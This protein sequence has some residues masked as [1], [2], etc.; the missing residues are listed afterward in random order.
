MEDVPTE[1][2]GAG[3]N[4]GYYTEHYLM[5]VFLL[6]VCKWLPLVTEAEKKLK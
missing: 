1:S 3:A 5:H 4:S 2:N 6:V